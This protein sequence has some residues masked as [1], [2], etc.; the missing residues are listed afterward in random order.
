[1]D[2]GGDAVLRVRTAEL[3]AARKLVEDV[4]EDMRTRIDHM[5]REVDDL[6]HRW[7]GDIAAEFE[8][9]WQEWLDGAKLVLDA[10]TRSAVVLGSAADGFDEVE[11][12][13][14]SGRA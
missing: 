3:R 4:S 12:S 13:G 11:N 6:M 8:P 5:R 1:M 7:K 14:S 2:S 9:N 10:L